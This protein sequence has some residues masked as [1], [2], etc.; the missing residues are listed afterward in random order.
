MNLSRLKEQIQNAYGVTLYRNAG[1]LI[2]N[3]F[4]QAIT[5]FLFW[6]FAARLYTVESVGF[7]SAAISAT[8]L[9][10]MFST[11]GLDYGLLK[12]LPESENKTRLM[13]SCFTVT[14]LISAVIS[15]VFISGIS[16]WAPKLDLIRGMP[17]L[18]ISF[19]LLSMATT[20]QIFNQQSYIAY[21]RSAF[22]LVQGVV[23]AVLRFIPLFLLTG[24]FMDYKIF[25]SW[26]IATLAAILTGIS[27]IPVVQSG[28]RFIPRLDIGLIKK[29]FSFSSQ[30]YVAYLLWSIP[31]II[32]PLLVLNIVGVAANAYFYI[33]WKIVMVLNFIGMGVSFALLAEGFSDKNNVDIHVKRSV[34]LLFLLVV[35]VA[36]VLVIFADKV[37]LLFGESYSMQAVTLLRI[38]IFASIP[39]N[40][41]WVYFS[42]KKLENKLKP[43]IALSGLIAVI[44]LGLSVFLMPRIGI[45]GAGYAWLASHLLVAIIVWLRL[46]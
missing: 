42:K 1:Y 11:L 22:A 3:S 24:Y 18:I 10:A 46:R 21:R 8:A 29:L 43:V 23:F 45:E 40:Y 30:N 34:K 16:V 28:Y 41:N 32:L 39:L 2:L 36:V 37:L 33:A 7:S 20:Q 38:L 19:V 6:I 4:I 17:V 15:I 13:N 27:L 12:F 9:I 25:A 14:L 35:P 31:D 5:G 26:G 44:T